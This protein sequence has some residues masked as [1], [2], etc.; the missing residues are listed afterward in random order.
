[1][2]Q[3]F[4][5]MPFTGV[6]IRDVL[7]YLEI[8]TV[9]DPFT[10]IVTPNVDHVVRNWRD[11]GD[12]VEIYEDA[13]LSLCDS[14]IVSLIGRFSG[15]PLPV[16]TG[17]DLTAILLEYTIDPQERITIIGG[18]EEV[19]AK[20]ARRYGL[21]DIRHHNPPMGFIRDPAAVLEA[22]QFVERNPSRFVF[23]AVGSPQQEILARSI[24][25][26]GRAVGIGM[27]V[28]ASLLFLTGD[29]QRA[30]VW[31][32]RSKLEW[33]HRLA[34]EP[35]RMWRR[36][37]YDAPKILRI[38]AEFKR[39]Q[40]VLVSVIVATARHEELLPRLIER[41]GAQAGFNA[42]AIEVIVV[43]RSAEASAR[44][45]VERSVDRTRAIIQYIHASGSSIA[46]ARDLGVA[47]AQGEF[48]AFIDHQACPVETW[49][50]A[51]LKIHRIYDADVV[52]GPVQAVF[53]APPARHAELFQETF[54]YSNDAATGT[55]FE[56]RRPMQFTGG[57]SFVP[58][59]VENAMMLKANYVP[60]QARAAEA[61]SGED[62]WFF[63]RM[64][65]DGKRLVWCAEAPV[66]KQIPPGM[67]RKRSLLYRTFR[68]S[69][70]TAATALGPPAV[71]GDLLAWLVI[72]ML[73][74][75]AGS[76]NALFWPIARDR[77][78]R[79]LRMVASGLGKF[80][81]FG[82]RDR[83]TDQQ[84]GPEMMPAEPPPPPEPAPPRHQA[85]I[86]L[87]PIERQRHRRWWRRSRPSKAA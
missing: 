72:G 45:I 36:Y 21:Q 71:I 73:Q 8:R 58:F 49:L 78:L 84:A 51:M 80:A 70:S 4:C 82:G 26:R 68:R 1:M 44:A 57:G 55:S 65:H 31:M 37:L 75:L 12:L 53:D 87:E 86:I 14:R 52:L 83:A 34:Q 56:K 35:K 15:V 6:G 29:L 43:D 11:K 61:G 39:E 17:S 40:R 28:G 7:R 66:E 25:E 27:C 67:L 38:A 16:V 24:K 85:S 47:K 5:E 48:V 32:Q 19:V 60:S 50:E 46:S 20:L 42:G 22:C 18:S 69:Q 76:L 54:S 10:Y 33:L 81:F 59:R 23:L 30:P 62:R 77:G 63:Q 79:G 9:N 3:K 64:L 41:C 74:V 2:K 13:E